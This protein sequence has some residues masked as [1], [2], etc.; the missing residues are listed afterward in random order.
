MKRTITG[1]AAALLGVG[2]LVSSCGGGKI[3]TAS[4]TE[5]RDSISYAIG[6]LNGS[7]YKNFLEQDSTINL[8]EFLKGLADGAYNKGSKSASYTQG[9]SIGE[10]FR[11]G[12][13]QDTTITLDNLV[14][15]F[16]DALRD[17]GLMTEDQAMEFMNSFQ[18]KMQQ[19]A[20]EEQQAKTAAQVEAQDKILAELAADAEVQ[21]TESGLMY[22][23]TKLGTGVKPSATD[24][25]TVHYKGTDVM[26]EVFDSSYDRNEPT[27]FPL[28]RVIAG[29][30]EGFQL[31][32]EGSTFTLWIPGNLAYGEL[33]TPTNGPAG[34]L[35]F[36]CELIKVSPATK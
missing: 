21:K 33:G 2:M 35:K 7:Q 4:F 26:G 14:A 32:P 24:T 5:D 6:I 8:D 29:W 22:K 28:D 36:E 30:T 20:A 27:S 13:E 10:N 16:A 3:K 18:M 15:G 11:K 17:K 9:Y 19:K 12:T 23:V 1:V 34:L 25:V 31:M